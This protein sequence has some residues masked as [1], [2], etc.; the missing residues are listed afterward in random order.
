MTLGKSA[1]HTSIAPDHDR[2]W[3]DDVFKILSDHD[4]LVEK[5]L[6]T[7]GVAR[8]WVKKNPDN[9]NVRPDRVAHL[10]NEMKTGQWRF[11]GSG[12]SF[13]REGHLRDGQHRLYAVIESGVPC[14]MAVAFNVELDAINKIDAGSN[15]TSADRFTMTSRS[16]D[17]PNPRQASIVSRA[18]L[19]GMRTHVGYIS[20]EEQLATYRNH[21]GGIDAATSLL[22]SKTKY[23]KSAVMASFAVAYPKDPDKIRTMF[24]SAIERTNLQPRS[25]ALALSHYVTE[26]YVK[27]SRA[28]TEIR[29]VMMRVLR[30]CKAALLDEEIQLLKEEASIF[31]WFGLS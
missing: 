14:E 23:N 31:R 2:F 5:V 20:Y 3:G 19:T 24:I 17:I 21:K 26:H 11:T 18:I 29:P 27:S 1:L 9:R 10:A 25:P 8:E 4:H 30:A 12:V 6:V 7:P 15:R 16:E 22:K 13:D 28:Q